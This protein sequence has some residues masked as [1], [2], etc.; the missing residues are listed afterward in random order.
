MET[1]ALGGIAMNMMFVLFGMCLFCGVVSI[2]VALKNQRDRRN[3]PGRIRDSWSTPDHLSAHKPIPH[4]H[5]RHTLRA[6]FIAAFALSCACATTYAQE[7][8]HG[9]T[10]TV[11]AANPNAKTFTLQADN[12]TVV[13]FDARNHG[14][15]PVTLAKEM[16]QQSTAADTVHTGA[17]VLV[18]YYGNDA[19]RNAVAIR[20]L[21]TG[22]LDRVN[23]NVA[24]FDRHQHRMKVKCSAAEPQDVVLSDQTVVDTPMGVVQGSKYK[25]N[26]GEQV[27]I[28]S[29]SS[30]GERTALFISATGP[31]ASMT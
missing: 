15:N 24:D 12:G 28:V 21:G 9:I 29:T 3:D 20:D 7:I 13:L 5:G 6:F 19:V 2:F 16:Q 25:P 10:G 31:N 27:G 30:K 18:F 14:G 11:T 8:V 4:W 23:G 26:K 22:A 1:E 17:H